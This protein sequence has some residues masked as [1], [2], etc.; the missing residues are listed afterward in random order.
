MIE[1][2]SVLSRNIAQQRG[3][4]IMT[5][6]IHILTFP[7]IVPREVRSAFRYWHDEHLNGKRWQRMQLR[8]NVTEKRE[9]VKQ[10]EKVEHDV[11]DLEDDLFLPVG[12]GLEDVKGIDV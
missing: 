10:L 5:S 12:V 9:A 3:S 11:A 7:S 8:M 2:A 1:A 4:T 6:P